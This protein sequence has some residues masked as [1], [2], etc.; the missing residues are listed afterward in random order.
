MNEYLEKGLEE[1]SSLLIDSQNKFLKRHYK[2][3]SMEFKMLQ[4]LLLI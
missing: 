3:L 2:G 1:K 4:N